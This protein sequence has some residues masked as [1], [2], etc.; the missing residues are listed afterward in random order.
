MFEYDASSRAAKQIV[1]TGLNGMLGQ[2]LAITLPMNDITILGVTSR[3]FNLLETEEALRQKLDALEDAHG[4]ID[5]IV[6]AAAYT[7]VDG[8]EANAELAMAINKEGTHKMVL[9]AKQRDI[10]L[11]YISTDYV[12][13]GMQPV[14]YTP[15][16]KPNPINV[17]GLSKYYGELMV[18]EHLEKYF[19]L[20]TSWVYGEHKPN[21]VSYVLQ[22]ARSGQ[23]MPVFTD[24]VGSPTWTGSL[25]KLVAAALQSDAY[26]TYHACDRGV[27]SRFEQAK[28][29]CAMA[30]LGTDHLVPVTTAS[31]QLTAKRPLFSA[32]DPGTLP[33][34]DWR[35]SLQHYLQGLSP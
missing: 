2:Q 23:Q 30:G 34:E 29:I 25:A 19:I 10:P 7:N 17:Y 9:L 24:Q 22:H 35:S 4:R 18:T 32:M 26:G 20:R 31:R 6:H 15:Q 11:V 33:T 8:A 13:D 27:V 16:D 5:A 14:P 28:I 12:F 3:A 21:F 1:V